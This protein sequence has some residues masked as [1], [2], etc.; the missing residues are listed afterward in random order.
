MIPV[1][2]GLDG[3]GLVLH[4]VHLPGVVDGGEVA[5]LEARGA[6]TDQDDL[7][8]EVAGRAPVLQHVGDRAGLEPAWH[9]PVRQIPE[10]VGIHRREDQILLAA[11]GQGQ[12]QGGD[13]LPAGQVEG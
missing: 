9:L 8:L 4:A 3:V 2:Q 6:G 13:A 11:L 12:G 10:A 5:V 7:I 1:Q